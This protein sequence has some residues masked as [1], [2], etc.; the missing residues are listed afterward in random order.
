MIPHLVRKHI[1][2]QRRADT[3]AAWVVGA[4]ITAIIMAVLNAGL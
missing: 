4:V 2:Q 3:R 1:D